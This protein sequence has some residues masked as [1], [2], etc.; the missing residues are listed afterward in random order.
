MRTGPFLIFSNTPIAADSAGDPLPAV[1]GDATSPPGSTITPAPSKNP[2]EIYVLNDRNAF[3]H[4][5]KFYFPELP[6]RRA[7]FL[8]QGRGG[9]STPT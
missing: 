6:P 9:S 3:T 7:F 4:F 5:L 2:V 1:A 8:A